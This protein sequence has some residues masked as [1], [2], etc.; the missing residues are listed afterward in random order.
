MVL[1]DG[2]ENSEG[3]QFNLQQESQPNHGDIRQ[4]GDNSQAPCLAVKRL[5]QLGDR[6]IITY[7]YTSVFTYFHAYNWTYF[8]IHSD[9]FSGLVTAPPPT[10]LQIP[11]SQVQRHFAPTGLPDHSFWLLC[12]CLL[13]AQSL[14]RVNVHF[15]LPPFISES[16]PKFLL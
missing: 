13:P 12:P 4:K 6:I 7:R 9:E 15:L 3:C 11:S 16:D 8:C 1:T 5:L 2:G 10:R 14:L